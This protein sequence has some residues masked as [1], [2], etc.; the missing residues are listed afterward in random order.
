[1]QDL[2]KWKIL[3]PQMNFE[4][5][6]SKE[7]VGKKCMDLSWYASSNMK[8]GV[9]SL[10]TMDTI[11][12]VNL[13]KDCLPGY[14]CYFGCGGAVNAFRSAP[15]SVMG[16]GDIDDCNDAYGYSTQGIVVIDPLF[17]D[18]APIYST[19]AKEEIEKQFILL[20]TYAK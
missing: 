8:Q 3:C 7:Y 20:T 18:T 5:I 17:P 2:E 14:G 6:W 11:K 15:Y 4:T 16:C 13:G 9:C 1:M 10:T 12:Y 19:P